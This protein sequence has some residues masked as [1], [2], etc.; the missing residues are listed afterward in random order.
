MTLR[1]LRK[2]R[3]GSSR[4][5]RIG[6]RITSLVAVAVM[7]SVVLIA[8]V[9]I[10]VEAGNNLATRR[11]AVEATAYVFAAAVADE[12]AGGNRQAVFE[13]LR[14]ISRIPD[15]TYALVTDSEG[16]ELASLG[17]VV[18][19]QDNAE[20]NANGTL[21][22]FTST[23]FPVAVDVL[24]GGT[25]IGRLIVVA[26]ISD[27]RA[28]LAWAL[29]LT[30]LGAAAAAG[31]GML[32]ALRL[33][34]RI[35][36][37]ILSLT[38][39][40]RE[41][42]ETRT[43]ATQVIHAS[44][45][46]TGVLVDTFN[47]MISDINARDRALE[48]HRQT[49]EST[50]EQRTHELSIAKD[51]AE[52]ANRAKSGFLA[53]MS[54]EIRTPMN[55]VMVMAELLAAGGLDH[56]QQRY[57]E[58]IVKSGQSLITIINDILDLSKIEAGQMDL[59]KIDLDPVAV[60]DDVV[61]LF[62]ERA[63]SKNL[64]LATRVAAGVPRLITGDPVRLN[65]IL[66][67]LVNNALKFTEKGQVL[68]S[69]G[70]DK[71]QLHFTVT[72]S[73]IGIP[74][75]KI[76]KLFSAF[77][78]A[79]GSITRKFGGTGLGLAICKKLSEAMGGSVAVASEP[80]RGSSFRLSIPV[81]AQA[82]AAAPAGSR[83][84]AALAIDGLATR[85]ALGTALATAGYS[86]ELSDGEPG[87]A[88]VLFIS[89]RRL[90]QLALDPSRRTKIVCVSPMGDASGETAVG[91]GRADDLVA[92]P[93]RHADIDELLVRLAAGRLRGKSLLGA[94]SA[95][96]LPDLSFARRRVL[97]A[98]DNAVNR[99]VLIEVLRQLQVS[100]DIAVDGREAVAKWRRTKPD[101]VFMD[102]SMPEMDGYAAT[103]EIRAHERLD[104]VD[105]HTPIVALTAHVA[106][107]SGEEWKAAGMDAYMTKPFT[108][109]SI[110]A[111]LEQQFSRAA[112]PIAAVEPVPAAA[113]GTILD[114]EV[115][116]ELRSIGGSDALFHRVLDIFA[117]KVPS[118][119][120]ALEIVK[121]TGDLQAMADAAHALKSMCA[122]IGARRALDACHELEHAAR[123]G[124]AFDAGEKLAVIAREIGFVVR[125][126]EELRA[127]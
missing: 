29:M 79:D 90:E 77:S 48:Q 121:E 113:A 108:M 53:T 9:F 52:A 92:Q 6:R 88:A 13:T 43:F 103:R 39:A 16:H 15:I 41:V 45:D 127:A 27:L 32:V 2:I 76:G 20:A 40:M 50:V 59:E 116:A 67:N 107:S 21:S 4:G 80:G 36:A 49:L 81:E 37:P 95:P 84:R 120:E 94:R 18:L 38:A 91:E 7:V 104:V 122:N 35:T 14:A 51:A 115:L 72:D 117:S 93:L 23:S 19:L 110:A 57:A 63:A 60:A 66:S 61:S 100:V 30:A 70:F 69:I 34:R 75:E 112:P 1:L 10:W 123:T 73:G 44:D 114:P 97:V 3:A 119:V 78:Q 125:E 26:D 5:G 55:G 105:R 8:S 65:Q 58:V 99:E 46:E 126:V 109:K 124:A 54:H 83:G 111:C 62:W 106:G 102:C 87:D 42:R 86:V 98:D 11:S 71:G 47:S 101:L 31:V 28:E 25:A 96:R 17:S 56:R 22:L 85:A 89:S 68:L 12:I 118:A 74:R 24:S 82:I 64:D 33:Q